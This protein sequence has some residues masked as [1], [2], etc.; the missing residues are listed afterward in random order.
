MKRVIAR[1]E[2][3]PAATAKMQHSTT[4]GRSYI[5]PCPALPCPALPA[6]GIGDAFHVRQRQHLSIQ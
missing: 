4:R 6:P 3:A 5:L 1:Y 2:S